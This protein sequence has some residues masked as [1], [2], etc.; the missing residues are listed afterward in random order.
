MMYNDEFETLPREAL[1]AL[2]INSQH[3]FLSQRRGKQ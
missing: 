3:I 2:Q 1:K